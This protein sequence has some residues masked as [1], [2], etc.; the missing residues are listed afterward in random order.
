MTDRP[1]LIEQLLQER[2]LILDCAMGTMIQK[3]R[4]EE[5]DF[6]GERCQGHPRDLK[7]NNDLLV[8]TRPDIIEGIHSACLDAGSDLIETNTFSSTRI[9]QA[10][11]GL[12][13]VVHELN[14]EA[15]RVARAAVARKM[16]EDPSRPRFV[17][18]AIG[19]T[20]KTLSLSPDVND[21]GFRA[22]TFDELADAYLEQIRGLAEGGVDVLLIET[23]FDTLNARRPCSQPSGISRKAASGCP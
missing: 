10:D 9:G 19:P 1:A 2:I 11:Y 16:K 22:V 14:R 13:S 3:H 12:E 23:I 15:A 20:N 4:L 7:G 6:R 17:A 21:P 5:K 18:G 8:L